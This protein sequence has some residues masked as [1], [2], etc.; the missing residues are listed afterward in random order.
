MFVTQNVNVVSVH[1]LLIT[2]LHCS[3]MCAYKTL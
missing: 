2:L 1:S 3:F